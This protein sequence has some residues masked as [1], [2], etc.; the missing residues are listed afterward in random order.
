MKGKKVL[1]LGLSKS[2]IAA[3]KCLARRGANVF[4]TEGKE[5]KNE[6]ISKITE[7]EN[8]GIK[9]ET[10]GHSDDFINNAELAVTSPGIPP[11]SEIMKKLAFSV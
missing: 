10:N 3:A 9:V 8:L 11:H 2:G 4:L 5:A 1:V 7:L 6:Y